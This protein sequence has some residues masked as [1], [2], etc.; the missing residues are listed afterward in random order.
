MEQLGSHWTNFH[1]IVY[2]YSIYVYIRVYMSI[3]RKS[4]EQIQFS[5]KSD[6]TNGRPTVH[7]DHYK[8]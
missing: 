2:I 8:F 3:F 5:L 1:E 7:E 6:K 4:V